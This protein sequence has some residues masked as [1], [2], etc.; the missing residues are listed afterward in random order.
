MA[1]PVAA[2][3]LAQGAQARELL[4]LVMVAQVPE[5]RAVAMVAGEDAAVLPVPDVLEME[6]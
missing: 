5:A 4:D 1:T 6:G 2:M 3:S